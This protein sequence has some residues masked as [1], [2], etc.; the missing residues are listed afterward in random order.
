MATL[1]L[2]Q[3]VPMILGGDELSHTRRGNNNPYCQ[4]NEITWYDWDL[5]EREQKF[6]EFVQKLTSFRKEHPSF[7]RRHFLDPAEAE[8]GTGDV[9]WWHPDGREMTHEDWHDNSLRAFGYLLRGQNLAP[10]AEGRPRSDAS[11]LV[12]MNQG[13]SPV[14]F[15][16][17]EETNELEDVRCKAWH[18]VPELAGD[19][20]QTEPIEPGGLLTLRPHR[21]LAL[22]AKRNGPVE[23][24]GG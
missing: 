17:P 23:E 21:L 4:D 15:E 1:L 10:D 8:N 16:V 13:D 14:E 19:L 9:L 11:F 3:G 12:L 18:I 20:G 7:R 5:D 22:R 2:S 6:L 24:S